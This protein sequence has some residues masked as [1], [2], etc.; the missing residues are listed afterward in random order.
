MNTPMGADREQFELW[1]GPA[2]RAW[3]E[4]QAMLDRIL[5][6]FEALL[7][8]AVPVAGTRA[9]L[10]VGCGTGATTLAAARRLGP[11]ASCVGIDI[12][13]PMIAYARTRAERERS[14][15]RFVCANAQS[16]AFP[17]SSFDRVISRFGVMF[18]DQP[19]AAFANLA[20]ATADGGEL[21]AIV[22]RGADENPFMTTAERTA[23][24][25][26]PNLP[27]RR[28]DAPGQFAFANPERVARILVDGGW[29]DVELQAIDVGCTLPE[30]ELVPYFSRLGPVGLA[31][32]QTDDAS[33]ARVIDAVRPAFDAYVHGADVRFTAACWM[34][35]ARRS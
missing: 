2:G 10:D 32:Q 13:D 16:H 8:D 3:I 14:P 21:R 26:L 31:L 33:R 30:S 25:L 5:Q 29:R 22:W 17:A 9:V 28:P 23:A 24:P 35:A 27:P 4:A 11:D 1:N 19:V 18:F 15:A 34:L 6:P 7:L 20:R 12:S